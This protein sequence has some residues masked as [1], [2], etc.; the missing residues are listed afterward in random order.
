MVQA[1][2]SII[3]LLDAGHIVLLAVILFMVIKNLITEH[4]NKTERQEMVSRVMAGSLTEYTNA[5]VAIKKA[6]DKIPTEE[7]AIEARDEIERKDRLP[8]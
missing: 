5:Q 3:S 7:E 2:M 4:F 1:E 8:V 6:N